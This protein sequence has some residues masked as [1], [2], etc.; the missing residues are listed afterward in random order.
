MSTSASVTKNKIDIPLQ[1][2]APACAAVDPQ[3]RHELIAQDA[4]FRAQHRGFAP[5]HEDENWCAAEMEVNNALCKGAG[6]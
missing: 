6:S 2:E 3:T 1:P 4:Y 5:G